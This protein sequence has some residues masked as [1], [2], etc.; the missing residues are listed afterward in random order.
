MV[1]YTL[2]D[3]RGMHGISVVVRFPLLC[4]VVGE[5]AVLRAGGGGRGRGGLPP[6]HALNNLFALAEHER[7]WRT[8]HLCGDIVFAAG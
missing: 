3:R 7:R 5:V 8:V 6:L 1:T 2:L 4:L